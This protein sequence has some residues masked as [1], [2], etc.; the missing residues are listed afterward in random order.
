MEGIGPIYADGRQRL[1]D[2]VSSASA[3][4]HLASVPGCPEWAVR[5]VLAHVTGVCADVIAGNV[6]GV[7]TE[8]WTAAQVAAR[9]QTPVEDILTEWSEVAPQVEA[10]AEMFPN[11]TDEQWVLDLTTHE[12]D[13]R[14]ALAQPG[15]RDAAGVLVGL[16]F[17]VTMGLANSFQARGLPGLRVKAA[18]REF[19]VGDG[20]PVA[21][22]EGTPFELFRAMTGRRSAAQVRSLAWEGDPELFIPA[23]E[24]GPF[25]FPAEDV[26][27]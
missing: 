10:V 16:D 22:L 17:A 9:K 3:D 23:F 4:Q 12:H 2:L 18:D 27:E 1:S 26:I 20:A 19:V 24:F 7:A 21:S 6:E 11:R 14:G 15:G 13:I 8:P 25:T 5:D